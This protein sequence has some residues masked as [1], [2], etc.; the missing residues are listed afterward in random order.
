[1]HAIFDYNL[2]YLK[3][4]NNMKNFKADTHTY[5]FNIG[6]FGLLH[7]KNS[8]I[9]TFTAIQENDAHQRDAIV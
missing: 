8:H 1:M 3:L 6:R 5:V 7:L 4:G 2:I 9:N